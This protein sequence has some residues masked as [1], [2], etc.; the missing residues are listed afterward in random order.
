MP[1]R[2]A[3]PAER[4]ASRTLDGEAVII[5]LESGVYFGLN[6]S[7]TTLWGLLEAGPRAADGLSAGL[8]DAHG[9]DPDEVARDVRLFLEGL[10][11]DGLVEST[12]LEEVATGS[13][14]GS[15]PYIAP[16]A[17]RYDKLDELMLSGE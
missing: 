14:P 13:V 7:A 1:S 15:G 9:A 12:D 11:R 4:V 16:I 5:N 6:V 10:E 3:V 2:Y 8:A 17:E